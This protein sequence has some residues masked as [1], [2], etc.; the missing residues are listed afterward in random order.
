[1]S[2]DIQLFNYNNQNLQT[3]LKDGEPWFVASD[4]ARILGYRD[5]ANMTRRLDEDDKEVR[6]LHT[7]G[8]NQKMT[9]ISYPGL[10][11]AVLGSKVPGAKHFRKWVTHTIL[12]AIQK[13]GSFSLAPA[14]TPLERMASAVLLAQSIIEEKDEVIA[15]LAPKA[16]FVD[17]LLESD[18]WYS[19]QEA[20]QMLKSSGIETGRKRLF[21]WMLENKW[22][23]TNKQPLQRVLERDWL[24]LKLSDHQYKNSEGRLVFA[25][26]TVMVTPKGLVRLQKL[27]AAPAPVLRVVESAPVRKRRITA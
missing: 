6:L 15:E 19:M 21:D 5:A 4:V 7:L 18:E 10:F 2:S 26:P 12:P 14:M 25:A 20:S 9:V 17:A 16:E 8:G 11:E 24:A 1:M 23:G 22:L 13:T 3:V 27:L